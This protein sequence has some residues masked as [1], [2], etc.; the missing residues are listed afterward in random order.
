MKKLK[1]LT[2]FAAFAL[3]FMNSCKKDND[4]VPDYNSAI[5][6]SWKYV[7]GMTNEKSLE[8]Y[9]EYA[10]TYMYMGE[11]QYRIN[12]WESALKSFEAA[13]RLGRHNLEAEKNI[14]LMLTLLGRQEEA[15]RECLKTLE[16]APQDQ[17]LLRRLASLYFGTGNYSAGLLYARRAYDAEPAREKPSFDEFLKALRRQAE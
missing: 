14:C 17:S 9:P 5:A 7:S 4:S 12:K 16:T 13:A 3:F 10:Q 6:G 1:V 8:V 11:M 15:I 2:V